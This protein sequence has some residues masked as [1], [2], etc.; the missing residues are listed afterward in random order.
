M[1]SQ[2]KISDAE[3]EVLEMLWKCEGAVKQTE[4]MQMFVAEGKEWKRQTL[5]TLIKRLEEKGLIER[6]ARVLKPVYSKIEYGNMQMK[7]TIEQIYD[8]KLSLFLASFSEQG[9]ISDSERVEILQMLE[10]MKKE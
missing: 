3:Y 10:Q 6:R 4:L 7:E 8:G 9:E 2:Y 5:N 1:R